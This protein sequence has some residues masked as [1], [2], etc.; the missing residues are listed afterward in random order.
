MKDLGQADEA[1][2]LGRASTDQHGLNEAK[3]LIFVDQDGYRSTC[4]MP[5]YDQCFCFASIEVESVTSRLDQAA[6][7]GRAWFLDPK[8]TFR[9]AQVDL[10][11]ESSQF[12]LPDPR[13]DDHVT[14]DVPEQLDRID[15]GECHEGGRIGDKRHRDSVG[16]T[17]HSVCPKLV[18]KILWFYMSPTSNLGFAEKT[19]VVE[20]EKHFK[21]RTALVVCTKPVLHVDIDK[22][23]ESLS[24]L[25]EQDILRL[26]E[27]A[28]EVELVRLGI[29]IEIGNSVACGHNYLRLGRECTRASQS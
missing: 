6:Y 27:Q 14:V 19:L 29:G 17:T 23:L 9:N 16:R 22:S 4:L 11:G 10:G 13:A 12:S 2:V 28:S 1:P 18:V 24:E 25:F 26:L 8:P 21:Q 15:A 7:F 3:R 5:R 20:I